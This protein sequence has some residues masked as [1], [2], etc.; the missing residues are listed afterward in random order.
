MADFDVESVARTNKLD[1]V[2]QDILNRRQATLD[3]YEQYVDYLNKGRPERGLND[4]KIKLNSLFWEVKQMINREIKNE[5][6]SKGDEPLYTDISELQKDI[7]SNDSKKVEKA[8]DYIESILYRK[9]I[10]MID[11]REA[12]DPKDV[13]EMNKRGFY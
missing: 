4:F 6:V 8:F 5:K 7:Q 12:I 3:S 9:R 10:T 13:F 2:K 1:K 11:T